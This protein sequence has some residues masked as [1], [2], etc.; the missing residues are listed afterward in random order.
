MSNDLYDALGVS[1]DADASDI[2]KAYRKL[3][4][5]YHPDRNPD[6]SEAEARFKEVSAAFEVLG[7][8]D[9][10]KLYDE[11]GLEGLRAGFDPNAARA[12]KNYQAGGGTRGF[13]GAYSAGSAFYEDI[14]GS[15]FKGAFRGGHTAGPG[16][17]PGAVRFAQTDFGDDP[18]SSLYGGRLNPNG[19]DITATMTL[20]FD[21]AIQ[22]GERTFMHH[23][24]E[25]RIN[26]P[27]GA[28]DGDT[29]RIKG[30]GEPAPQNIIGAAP[31]DLRI[32]LSVQPHPV[33]ERD[34][35]DLIQHVV[36]TMPDSILGTELKI[37]TPQGSVIVTV[38][39]GTASG[40]TLRLSKRGVK[41]GSSTGNFLIKIDIAPPNLL[42]DHIKQLA[43]QL[44][45]G[46][47]DTTAENPQ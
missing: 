27:S 12:F 41:R 11:F 43:E 21:T 19:A 4:L 28:R 33:I 26:I 6:D 7:D 34:G 15:I 14:I 35:L 46:Y 18:F 39:P 31:G 2:K 45:A 3:A 5:A 42:N 36:I 17:G 24:K 32:R 20:D 13:T 47:S 25:H 9:K 8:E 10:R 40:T 29:L 23:G 38:K 16:A 44:R 37:D 1:K 30:K 22:G